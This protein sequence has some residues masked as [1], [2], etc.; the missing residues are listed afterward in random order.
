M[1]N[2]K[3]RLL[4]DK[5]WGGEDREAKVK[6]LVNMKLIAI[7]V[8]IFHWYHTASGFGCVSGFNT[9]NRQTSEGMSK[10]VPHGKRKYLDS[11]GNFSIYFT[12]LLDCHNFSRFLTFYWRI[13]WWFIRL[14][15]L[16]VLRPVPEI[17]QISRF[18]G[19]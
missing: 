12:S 6:S 10:W 8:D 7:H 2:A 16:S 13:L 11:C 3:R 18:S 14:L 19:R 5:L 15:W 4:A 9:V 1:P 17:M